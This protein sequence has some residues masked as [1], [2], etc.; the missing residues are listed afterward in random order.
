MRCCLGLWPSNL[1]ELISELGHI[2]FSGN[3]GVGRFCIH[4]D[5]ALFW[6]VLLHIVLSILNSHRLLF[7]IVHMQF[8]P[9]GLFN[10]AFFC[11]MLC[12]VGVCGCVTRNSTGNLFGFQRDGGVR[13]L[14]L[15]VRNNLVLC[16]RWQR[17]PS[18]QSG[19]VCLRCLNVW[20][21]GFFKKDP[22]GND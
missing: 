19:F 22:D 16:D 2:L 9:R 18:S 11:I 4:L 5:I 21:W 7:V 10:D 17:T 8:F 6:Y 3:E 20:P 12:S 1:S 15:L 14:A 13:A